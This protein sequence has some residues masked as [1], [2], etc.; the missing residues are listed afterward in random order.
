MAAGLWPGGAVPRPH[1]DHQHDRRL[2]ARHGGL[3]TARCFESLFYVFILAAFLL[4]ERRPAFRVQIGTNERLVERSSC[5][6][7][8]TNL[9]LSF[10]LE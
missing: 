8:H 9:D 7:W 6:L 4:I 5:C 3:G 1:P 10:S 2:D